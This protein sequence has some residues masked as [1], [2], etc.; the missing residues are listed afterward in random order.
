MNK[1][2]LCQTWTSGLAPETLPA[3]FIPGQDLATLVEEEARPTCAKALNGAFGQ[4]EA[5]IFQINRAFMGPPL[6]E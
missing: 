5:K 1:L 2:S 6:Q 4:A 3:A